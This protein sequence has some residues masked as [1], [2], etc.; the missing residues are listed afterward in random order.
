MTAATRLTTKD[1]MG[2]FGVT[3]MTVYN[4]RMGSPTR[5]PLPAETVG[6]SVFY[7]AARVKA[8][9]RRH[10]VPLLRELEP[11]TGGPR[12]P[13]PKAQKPKAR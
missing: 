10:G 5:E 8:W 9:A 6:R 3:P 1:V 4:W 12:K 2:A 7:R 11:A 13:G